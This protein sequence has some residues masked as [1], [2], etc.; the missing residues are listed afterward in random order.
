MSDLPNAFRQL[1]T[2]HR[3][4]NVFSETEYIDE[5][6][7]Q[8][9]LGPRELVVFRPE[10]LALHELIIRVTADITV[11]EGSDEI[12]LG[13]NF[14]RIVWIILS[15][16]I[17]PH[18]GEI[19]QAYT[20]LQQIIYD[21]MRKELDSK[22][23]HYVRAKADRCGAIPHLLVDRFRFDSFS[24]EKVSK[25]LHGTYVKHVDTMYMYFVVTPPEETVK[26][27]WERGLKTGRYKAVEDFLDHS[28]EAYT[29]MPKLLFKWLAYKRPLFKYRF[30]DNSVPKGTYPRTIAFGT[31]EEMNVIDCSAFIDIVRYQKIN[32]RARTPDEVYPA[33]P[34]L[35]VANNAV[36]LKQCI[37]HLPSVNFID[38]A[39]GSAY[40]IATNG[41]FTV[42]HAEM[43]EEKLRDGERFQIFSEIAPNL[44]SVANTGPSGG[45]QPH[46]PH[47]GVS[48]TLIP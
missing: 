28:V 12:E 11:L 27:G 15:R 33:E 2:I 46:S 10:R 37:K 16:Y 19:T 1:E 21:R 32:V 30:L 13:K 43:F 24:S 8:T 4:E 9:G 20:Q 26:R 40:V 14:R 44:C 18:M 36:F 6:S 39:T 5:V 22:L 35:S 42:T 38:E 25:I 23:D 45:L 47:A 41:R 17:Q 31:Q 34:A 3:P 29:G 7:G 48:S